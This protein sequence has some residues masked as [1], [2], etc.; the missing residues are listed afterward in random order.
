MLNQGQI[1]G[2]NC[3]LSL[4]LVGFGRTKVKLFLACY[5]ALTW[6]GAR[7]GAVVSSLLPVLQE[8]LNANLTKGRYRAQVPSWTK[9]TQ[10]SFWFLS[11]SS[12]HLAASWAQNR[13]EL[14]AEDTSCMKAVGPCCVTG[15]STD[16][17]PLLGAELGCEEKHVRRG[18]SHLGT[19]SE[20]TY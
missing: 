11:C 5:V 10:W 8:R 12:Q 1:L 16:S 2:F 3:E 4:C 17:A 18:C 15:P 13:R 7:N 19:S 9:I 20:R 14:G 6:E